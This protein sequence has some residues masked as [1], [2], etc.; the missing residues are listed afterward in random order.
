MAQKWLHK[1]SIQQLEH[2]PAHFING[3][4]REI[5]IGDTIQI[6]EIDSNG[7]VPVAYAIIETYDEQRNGWSINT[8]LTQFI[9]TEGLQNLRN[10]TIGGAYMV[11]VKNDN[12]TI[13]ARGVVK[14]ILFEQHLYLIDLIDWGISH[15]LIFR[16]NI[17][18]L[19]FQFT[20]LYPRATY[21]AMSQLN[22]WAPWVL[23]DLLVNRRFFV[24]SVVRFNNQ[25]GVLYDVGLS[26]IPF[27]EQKIKDDIGQLVSLAVHRY[28][29]NYALPTSFFQK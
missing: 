22:L 1:S 2:I 23:K 10:V 16:A 5:V 29:N 13:F 6:V 7:L 19:P 11:L 9:C 18:I 20:Y 17:F 28:Q 21:I 3:Y 12:F 14:K 4:P 24:T 8:I 26:F 27:G 15:V 25:A